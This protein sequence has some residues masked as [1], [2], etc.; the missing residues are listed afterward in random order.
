VF[1]DGFTQ[2][3]Y[4]ITSLQNGNGDFNG[5]HLQLDHI[6]DPTVRPLDVLF[7]EHFMQCILKNMRGASEQDEDDDSEHSS[8]KG[9]KIRVNNCIRKLLTLPRLESS[10]AFFQS[11]RAS[12]PVRRRQ[13]VP[14]FQQSNS[15]LG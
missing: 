10:K 7:N 12:V 11:L 13:P 6:H 3:N 2:N 5:L 15:S 4:R 9:I 8:S 14:E 1:D